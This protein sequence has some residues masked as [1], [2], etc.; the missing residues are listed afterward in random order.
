MPYIENST[1]RREE[2]VKFRMPTNPGELN[3]LL[4]Y[5][6]LDFVKRMG[7]TYHILDDIVMAYEGVMQQLYSSNHSEYAYPNYAPLNS[8][9]LHGVMYHI[10]FNY[11]SRSGAPAP[12]GTVRLSQAEFI[13]EVVSPYEDKKKQENGEV[14]LKFK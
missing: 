5:Q 8:Q 14:R 10:V 13:R 9:D 1:G 3:F 4:Y 6:A 12:I 2:L 7:I 11:M